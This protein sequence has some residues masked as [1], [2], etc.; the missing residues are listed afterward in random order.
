MDRKGRDDLGRALGALYRAE[1]ASWEAVEGAERPDRI[2]ACVRACEEE[3]AVRA[4]TDTDRVQ[5]ARFLRV[6][7]RFV[8][9][10]TWASFALIAVGAAAG[11]CLLGDPISR[12]QLLSA[13]GGFLSLT[14]LANV[15]RAKAHGMAEL[16]GAC[17]FNAVA[18]TCARLLVMGLAS[19]AVVAAGCLAWGAQGVDVMRGLSMM[20]ASYL[21]ACAGGLMCARRAAS[22]N[23]RV[24]AVTWAAGVTAASSALLFAAPTTYAATSTWIWAFACT[25][26]LAWCALEVRAWVAAS[27]SGFLVR[28]GVAYR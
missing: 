14:C 6:Q 22:A 16:E 20:G 4:Q 5:T 7:M 21:V 12:A 2:A 26:A 8:T 25:A 23:A 10:G 17:R 15:T 28:T 11:G 27:A 18:V 9:P 13:A 1:R 19:A 3:L 24:A